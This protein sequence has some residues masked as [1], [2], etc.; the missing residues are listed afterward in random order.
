MSMSDKQFQVSVRAQ[1]TLFLDMV[2]KGQYR[3]AETK[4]NLM[5][6]F[7]HG[8]T[9]ASKALGHNLSAEYQGMWSAWDALHAAWCHLDRL[10]D[11]SGALLKPTE[12]EIAAIQGLAS[13]L[14]D[15][16]IEAGATA[17]G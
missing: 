16:A 17:E 9:F 3:S 11:E 13:A 2:S 7:W 12:K 6:Y 4:M 1:A 8:A 5:T 10:G 14:R 15:R